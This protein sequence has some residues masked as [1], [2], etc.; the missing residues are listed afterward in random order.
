[1]MACQESLSNVI[2]ETGHR[3]VLGQL[4]LVITFVVF[5]ENVRSTNSLISQKVEFINACLLVRFLED[6]SQDNCIE[7]QKLHCCVKHLL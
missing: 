3:E 7:M 2:A 1:M 6:N 4:T 5:W